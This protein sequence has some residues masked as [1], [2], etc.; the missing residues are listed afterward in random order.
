M[1]TPLQEAARATGSVRSERKTASS[2]VN[3][4]L[5]GRPRKTS[6]RHTLAER[7]LPARPAVLI[8]AQPTE[9]QK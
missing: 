9:N 6:N 3:G 7:C 5:G 4:K 1:T 2:R 8:P